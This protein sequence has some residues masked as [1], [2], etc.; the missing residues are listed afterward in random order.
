MFIIKLIEELLEGFVVRLLHI[1]QRA[2]VGMVVVWM[3]V[4]WGGLA[5]VVVLVVEVGMAAV[6]HWERPWKSG[7]ALR[8]S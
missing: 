4:G 1:R 7:V 6:H 8:R 3:G 5:A 2:M